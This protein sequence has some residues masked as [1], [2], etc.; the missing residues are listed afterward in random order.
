MPDWAT[1]I[2]T[3][4]AGVVV[5]YLVSFLA[6]RYNVVVDGDTQA[7]LT[8]SLVAVFTFVYAIVH[9]GSETVVNAKKSTNAAA[10]TSAGN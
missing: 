6:N 5:A 2:L 7:H 9:K 10:A 8:L 3:R 4:A 1:A